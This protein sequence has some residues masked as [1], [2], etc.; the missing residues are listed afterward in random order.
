MGY[1]MTK[2][3]WQTEAREK[4]GEATVQAINGMVEGQR[5]FNK[6]LKN[7][8][9]NHR[10]IH[11][12]VEL[13]ASAF[14]DNDFEGHKIYHQQLIEYFAWRKKFQRAIIE[15]TLLSLI[16]AGIIFLALAVY[17]ELQTIIIKFIVG[18][19]S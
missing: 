14:P 2:E 1:G 10:V 4:V 9:D 11:S 6:R 5:I 8:E 15:K 7:M 12:K 18:G 17:H 13:L 3:Y 19:K 16:Y